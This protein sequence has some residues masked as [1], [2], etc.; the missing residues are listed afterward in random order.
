L[1][2]IT[3]IYTTRAVRLYVPRTEFA[4]TTVRRAGG[5]KLRTHAPALELIG[6]FQ[7]SLILPYSRRM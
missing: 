7:Q 1:R 5:R 6:L 2:T 3:S 4:T